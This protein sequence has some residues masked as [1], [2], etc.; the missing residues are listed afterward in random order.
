MDFNNLYRKHNIDPSKR[1]NWYIRFLIV[2]LLFYISVQ[3]TIFIL[4]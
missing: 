2:L 1:N 3:I 4:F